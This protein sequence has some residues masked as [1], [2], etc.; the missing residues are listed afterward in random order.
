LLAA[1]ALAVGCCFAYGG[2]WTDPDSGLTWSYDHEGGSEGLVLTGFS[3]TCPENLVIPSDIPIV[4]AVG[5][6]AVTNAYFV[7]GLQG[8]CKN[9][10]NVKSVVVPPMVASLTDG[11][12]AGCTSLESVRFLGPVPTGLDFGL[13]FAGTPY[14][15]GLEAA[16]DN[17]Y[18]YIPDGAGEY[19]DAAREISGASG[20]A[21]D[22]NFLATPNEPGG[23]DGVVDPVKDFDPL[24]G[25]A[26]WLVGSKW[27]KW[28]APASTTVWFDTKGSDFDT[29]LG[30]YIID[31]YSPDHD[32]VA[33]IYRGEN[34]GFGGKTSLVSFEL[35]QGRT[36][37][38]CVGGSLENDKSHPRGNI[39][40]N[41]RTGTPVTLT[42][43]TPSTKKATQFIRYKKIPVPKGKPVEVLPEPTREGYSFAGWYTKKA[44]GTKVTASTRFTKATTL[45][46]RWTLRK[47]RVTLL[48]GEGCAS[49]SGQGLHP[50]GS[51][52]TISAAALPGYKFR[53]WEVSE[54][55]PSGTAFTNYKSLWRKNQTAK[56]KIP[57]GNVA[58]TA[59]FVKEDEDFLSLIVGGASTGAAVDAGPWYAEQTPS[60]AVPVTANSQSYPTVT[61]SK[62]PSGTTFKLAN[63]DSEYVFSVPST[64][65]LPPG[66]N[67]VKVTAKNRWGMTTNVSL[68]VFGKN[69][70]AANAWLGGIETSALA[71][72]PMTVGITPS[73]A[74]LKIVPVRGCTITKMTGLPTGLS[75]DAKKKA[76]TGY[77][78]RTGTYTVSIIASLKVGKR[79][80]NK[81]STITVVVAPLPE[82]LAGVFYGSTRP[83]QD[84]GSFQLSSDS[85]V[86]AL[87]VATTGKLTAK[88][89]TSTFSGGGLKYLPDATGDRYE[90]KFHKKTS[91]RVGKK[92]RTVDEWLTL[93]INPQ[94]DIFGPAFALEDS[95]YSRQIVFAGSL[96]ISP[97][98]RVAGRLNKFGKGADGLPKDAQWN[99]IAN[100]AAE[101]GEMEFTAYMDEGAGQ[102]PVPAELKVW[103]NGETGVATL[104]GT[105]GGTALEGTAVL[106]PEADPDTVGA[107]ANAAFARFFIGTYVIEV[108]WPLHPGPAAGDIVGIGDPSGRIVNK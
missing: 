60:L 36:Y 27:Y 31:S 61:T 54:P 17:D 43:M 5:N 9:R 14:L 89:G 71:P 73:F 33:Y 59:T 98:T 15:A 79:L 63:S 76:F 7:E 69:K 46:A 32:Q 28:T 16:N 23:D 4:Q 47:Y 87:T 108:K 39:V 8:V 104:A 65:K 26:G 24:R 88:V 37:H 78:T 49:L 34:K 40:L 74:D 62:L 103:V 75:W 96:S 82:G 12:F 50:H 68:V 51:S 13:T 97:D 105:L 44:G 38:I 30:A 2:A 45:Y 85:Q 3:G 100:L 70:T 21:R 83:V 56:I 55:I 95:W 80:T 106:S 93:T 10:T 18:L 42:L 77:P 19:D 29:V 94:A 41:W 1:A 86:V 107:V 48:P 84:D 11:A 90:A 22:N 6:E 91:T 52:V 101:R 67:V 99:A 92:T 57:A 35:M 53:G 102:N 72:Y 81:V 66:R 58:Y 25:Y 64:A 20:T